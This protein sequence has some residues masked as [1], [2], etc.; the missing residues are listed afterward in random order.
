M[1]LNKAKSREK[2]LAKELS[3]A[4]AERRAEQDEATRLRDEMA[5]NDLQMR[6]IQEQLEAETYFSVRVCF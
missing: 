1:D 2:Q 3:D 4:R 5:V 6:E